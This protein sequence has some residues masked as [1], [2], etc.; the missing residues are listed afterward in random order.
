MLSKLAI[1]ILL[2]VVF[3]L[4]IS[5]QSKPT[6]PETVTKYTCAA[7]HWEGPCQAK[8]GQSPI[9]LGNSYAF[10]D[11][12][13][14][15]H[16]YSQR[17]KTFEEKDMKMYPVGDQEVFARLGTRKL[18]LVEYHFH[19]PSE[20]ILEGQF[21]PL[22]A[23]FV[24]Q[25]EFGLVA[26]GIFLA[27]AINGI[28]VSALVD[29]LHITKSF[30]YVGSLTTKPCTPELH[31]VI[32]K[33]PIYIETKDLHALKQ[34]LLDYYGAPNHRPLQSLGDRILLTDVSVSNFL[35]NK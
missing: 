12:L 29:N 22:E 14:A 16:F 20:H 18:K 8:Q 34:K 32:S 9:A 7:L 30:R 21:Y 15:V 5:K 23:H 13:P 1:P 31:W 6:K 25:D 19:T 11:V 27:Q 10:K 2:F 35:T 24:T 17:G 33:D 3:F 26:F 28:K 4:L